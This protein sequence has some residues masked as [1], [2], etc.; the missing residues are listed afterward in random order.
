MSLI[1]VNNI[2]K[3]KYELELKIDSETFLKG[4]ESAYKRNV[5]NVSIPG[6]RKGKAPRKMIEKMYGEHVF[7]EEAINLVYPKVLSDAIEE[8]KLELVTNPEIEVISAELSDGVVLK[9]ICTTKPE[10]EVGEYKGIQVDKVVLPINDEAVDAELQKMRERNARIV[11]IEDRPVEKG[12]DVIIDFE[13]FIDDVAFDGGKGENHNLTIGSGQFIPGFEDQ[14]IGHNI[15]DSFD[16]NISFPEEYHAKELAGKAAVFKVKLYE[17]KSK[18]LPELDD[19][20]AKD[21]SEFDILSE[22]KDSIN[23]K[24]AEQSEKVAEQ[25]VEKSIIDYIISNIKGDIPDVMY[26]NRIDDTIRDFEQKLKSQGMSIDI[27]L[28]YTGLTE[29]SFRDSFREQAQNQV[30]LRLALEKIASIEN[31]E[32]TDQEIDEKYNKFT[33]IYKMSVE[34]IKKYISPKAVKEDIAVQKAIDLVKEN[35]KITLKDK[36]VEKSEELED[37]KTKTSKTQKKATK[38]SETTSTKKT[39]TTRKKSDSKS[40]SDDDSKEDKTKTRKRTTKSKKEEE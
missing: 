5:K 35:A 37:K 26:E 29:Q 15:D 34:D 13:G 21:V 14:I 4:I 31:L 7:F 27:Y 2:E 12:D 40:K 25:E 18:E 17:I 9:A 36:K 22:L 39:T 8:S 1:S 19:E 30:K 3:N 28:Q 6:F 33:E 10:I 20:F 23:K 11:T 32:V 38:K 16:V 24:L